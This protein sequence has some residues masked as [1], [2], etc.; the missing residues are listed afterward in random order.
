MRWMDEPCTPGIVACKRIWAPIC[1]CVCACV[2]ACVRVCMRVR[3]SI[4]ARLGA[5][6]HSCMHVICACMIFGDSGLRSFWLTLL[7]G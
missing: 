1:V 2:R 7:Y 3:I 6:T 4:G 5:S